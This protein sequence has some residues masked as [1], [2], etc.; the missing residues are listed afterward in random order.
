MKPVRNNILLAVDIKQKSDFEFETDGGLT[1]WTNKDFGTNNITKSPVIATVVSPGKYTDLSE[2]DQVLCHHLAFS[3]LQDPSGED[4]DSLYGYTGVKQ[5]GL[6]VFAIERS[7]IFFKVD[8][9]GNPVPLEGYIAGERINKKYDGLIEVPDSAR[10]HFDT[11]FRAVKVG[12]GCEGITDG[13]ILITYKKSDIM[14]EYTFKKKQ[15]SF[16]RIRA[17]DVLAVSK[18]VC[19]G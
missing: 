2:G 3:R 14:V 5:D 18:E 13:D 12:A 16:V 7:M 9:N 6:W 15:K 11:Q 1:L 8:D 17:S 10:T 4:Q 19:Y